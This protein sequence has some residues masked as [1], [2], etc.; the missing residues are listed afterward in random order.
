M[1]KFDNE[2]AAAE[3]LRILGAFFAKHPNPQLQAWTMGS[4]QKLLT[5]GVQLTGSPA[6]WMAGLVYSIHNFGKIPCGGA[7]DMLNAEF[8]AAFGGVPMSTVRTRSATIRRTLDL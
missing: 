6:G 4:F 7:P 8:T 2:T 1:T 5:R 3:C